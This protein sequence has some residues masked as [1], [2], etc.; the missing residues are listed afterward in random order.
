MKCNYTQS[1][2]FLQQIAGILNRAVEFAQLS[3]DLDSDRLKGSAG[4]V[5]LFVSVF[6]RDGTADDLRQFQRRF[7]WFL[8]ARAADKLRNPAPKTL[9]AI[10]P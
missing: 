8:C 1:S 4:G 6:C 7:N 10:V 2:A 5:L 9:F 3:I